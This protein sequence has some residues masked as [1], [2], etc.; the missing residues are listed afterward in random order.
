MNISKTGRLAQAVAEISNYNSQAATSTSIRFNLWQVAGEVAATSPIT[1][2]GK[3][4]LVEYKTQQVDQGR[5]PEKLK[6]FDSS[7]NAYMNTVARRGLIGLAILCT[8]LWVPVYIAVSAIRRGSSEEQPYAY[9]LL[10]FGL[11]FAIANL[12]QDMIFLNNGIIMYTGLLI[13]LSQMLFQVQSRPSAS[14]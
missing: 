4:R 12:T 6:R 7:H 8:F 5:F 1:G 2:V 13:I 11:V 3:N 14:D 9:A 10:C